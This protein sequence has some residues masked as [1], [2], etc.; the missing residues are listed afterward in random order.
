VLIDFPDPSS[1]E[2]AKLYSREFYRKL[3]RVL[4]PGAVLALQ[5]TS[6]YHA[7]EAFLCI[8]RTL[9][10]AGFSALPYHDNVPSFGS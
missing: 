9:E 5:S 2:L 4:A 8:L 3:R 7:R 6:P 10:S 1:V